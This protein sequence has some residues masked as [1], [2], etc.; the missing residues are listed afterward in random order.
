M[1]WLLVPV[2]AL[3]VRYVALITGIAAITALDALCPPEQMVPGACTAGW[4]AVSVDVLTLVLAALAA[5]G[6]V[7]APA[8]VAPSHGFAVAATAFGLGAAATWIAIGGGMLGPFAAAAA[9]GIVGLIL[10]ARTYR[11]Q[12]GKN[13]RTKQQSESGGGSK[14]PQL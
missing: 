2:T 1:R 8:S 7:L 6:I 9:G 13:L 11:G 10:A 12:P 14:Q 5:L 3:A 4:H